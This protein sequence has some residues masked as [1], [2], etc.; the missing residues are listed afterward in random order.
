[1]SRVKLVNLALLVGCTA[2]VLAAFGLSRS[3]RNSFRLPS[4]GMERFSKGK[5]AVEDFK[6]E[7]ISHIG[8]YKVRM[9]LS[10]PCRSRA[11][12]KALDRNRAE[13]QNDFVLY[14]NNSNMKQS[15]EAGN[16]QAIKARLLGVINQY[17]ANP[18][19]QVYI[20]SFRYY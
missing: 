4:L 11:Q 3:Y 16:M 5:G 8:Q 19:D 7:M 13:L 15:L 1:M 14:L 2:M 17:S 9:D 20:T 18:V 12:H 6:F 10:F